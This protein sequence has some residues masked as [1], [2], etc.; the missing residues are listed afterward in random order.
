MLL[1]LLNYKEKLR[2]VLQ[3]VSSPTGGIMSLKLAPMRAK[4][5]PLLFYCSSGFCF[6]SVDD[7][8]IMPCRFLNFR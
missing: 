2:Q 7:H 6:S 1:S 5:R 4:G 3:G 8:L